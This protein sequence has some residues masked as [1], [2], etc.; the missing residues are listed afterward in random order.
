MLEGTYTPSTTRQKRKINFGEADTKVCRGQAR[1][2]LGWPQI[3]GKMVRPV[4]TNVI[5]SSITPSME[6][7]TAERQQPDR[8]IPTASRS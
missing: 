5:A 4:A 6:F 7:R 2:A 3:M 1:G 8:P